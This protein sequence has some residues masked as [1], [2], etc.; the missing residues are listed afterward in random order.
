MHLCHFRARVFFQL[1]LYVLFA[2]FQSQ[3]CQLSVTVKDSYEKQPWQDELESATSLW[4]LSRTGSPSVTGYRLG[5][6]CSLF[7]QMP[8]FCF[9][10]AFQSN[11]VIIWKKDMPRNETWVVT[12]RSY[13]YSG[14]Y[15]IPIIYKHVYQYIN[16]HNMCIAKTGQT[17]AI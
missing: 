12:V 14:I 10:F 15:I 2:A 17:C 4:Q 8:A 9:P 13:S 6:V 7:H 1:F 16:M 5:H 3:S 11:M